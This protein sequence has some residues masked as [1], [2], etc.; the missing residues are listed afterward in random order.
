MNFLAAAFFACVLCLAAC[1]DS[2]AD[3]YGLTELGLPPGCTGGQAKAVNAAG[4]VT[5]EVQSGTRY[6]HAFFYSHGIMAEIAVLP[7]MDSVGN[8]LSDTGRVA[9]V[10]AQAPPASAGNTLV[11]SEDQPQRVHAFAVRPGPR[12]D[13]GGPGLSLSSGIN[14]AGDIVGE[15]ITPDGRRRAFLYRGGQM[16]LL[17]TL[18]LPGSGW[19][20]QEAD[21]IND[22]G[23]IA[24]TG[25]HR[26]VR[27]AFLL[28]CGAVT[29]LNDGLPRGSGW[30]LEQAQAINAA[31]DT[32][33]LGKRGDCSHIFLS[34]HGVAVDLGTLPEFP[35]LVEAHLNN[36][37][38]IVGRAESSAGDRQCAFL[39]S[40]GRL[41]DLNTVLPPAA[42]W[43]LLDAGGINDS[44]VIAG[45]GEHEGRTRL[46]LLTPKEK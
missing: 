30:T 1:P 28:H 25:L 37:G 31:G 41:T 27:H 19:T 45:T 13:F 40:G 36:A 44:G 29:D 7:G 38:Q 34:R 33:S 35:N 11:S 4:E 42:H 46:F 6:S 43:A 15:V 18:L 23:D 2:R 3:S 39:Y 9:G 14:R 12:V 22:R 32:V 20:L 8:A 21:A 24:G 17:D 16:V 10:I 5:G 26:G